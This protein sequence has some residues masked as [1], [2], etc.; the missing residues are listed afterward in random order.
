MCVKVV[1]CEQ[2]IHRIMYVLCLA[3]NGSMSK[4]V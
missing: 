4:S 3:V 1:V 2:G